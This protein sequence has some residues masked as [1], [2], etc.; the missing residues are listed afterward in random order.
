[1]KGR[2]YPG[3]DDELDRALEDYGSYH[4]FRELERK[5]DAKPVHKYNLHQ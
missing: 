1:M 2:T 4:K 5:E 3:Y